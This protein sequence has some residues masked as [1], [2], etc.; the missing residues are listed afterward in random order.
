MDSELFAAQALVTSGAN[1]EETEALLSKMRAL[2]DGL[3]RRL[4]P[5]ADERAKSEAVLA[6]LYE[7]TLFRYSEFQTR[8]DVAL[9]SGD[10][11]CVSSAILFCYLA[12][13][14]G[15]KVEGV[16]T[17]QHAFCTVEID[18]KKIDVET[19][20]PYGFDPGSRK[21]LPETIAVQK[22]YVLVPQADYR[23]RKPVDDRRLLSLVYYNRIASLERNGNFEQAIALVVDAWRLQGRAS[24]M[25]DLTERFLNYAVSLSDSGKSA[26]GLDF[27]QKV[28]AIWGDYPSYRDYTAMALHF[29]VDSSALRDSLPKISQSR[30]S[31]GKGDYEQ[32]TVYA[33]SREAERLG[34]DGKWLEAASTLDEGLKELPGQGDLLRLK[35][36]CRQNY[37]I[38]IHNRAVAAY[39]AGNI[40]ALKALIKE[41]LKVAPESALLKNDLRMLE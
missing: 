33:Y 8:V 5:S 32:L 25:K 41:G 1:D 18:G 23:D 4:P 6:F 10:Y 9:E 39:R 26:E 20:N 2:S 11:N 30:D 29:I 28:S 15:L 36:A 21:E 16:E 19:T 27:I 35:N 13:T 7:T 37:A 14:L 34:R 17:A 38:D 3:K 40:E 24:P 22:R 12:K 31:L